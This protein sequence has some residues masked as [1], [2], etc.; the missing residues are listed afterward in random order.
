MSFTLWFSSLGVYLRALI[1]FSLHTVS[2]TTG[3]NR[4]KDQK[5]HLLWEAWYLHVQVQLYGTQG[6]LAG[7][8]EWM[9]PARVT[10]A[11]GK[12]SGGSKWCSHG[13]PL[14]PSNVLSAQSEAGFELKAKPKTFPRVLKQT[15]PFLLPGAGALEPWL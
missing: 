2:L 8:L 9:R 5:C 14:R 13:S 7:T 3:I 10:V 1:L 6:S 4:N 12:G 11:L 15:P